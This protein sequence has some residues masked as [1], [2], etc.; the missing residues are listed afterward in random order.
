MHNV[1][2]ALFNDWRY[3]LIIALQVYVTPWMKALL[4]RAFDYRYLIF[5]L[6]ILVPD[7]SQFAMPDL[8]FAV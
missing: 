4:Y 1:T 5:Y 6:D 2:S 7:Y 8:R 3:L